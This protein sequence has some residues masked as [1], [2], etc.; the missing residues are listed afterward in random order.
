MEPAS[1]SADVWIAAGTWATVLVLAGTLVYAIKQVGEAQELRRQQ[2]RPWVTVSFH[3][4]SNIAFIAVKN[5]GSTAAHDVRIRFEPELVSA[6]RKQNELA[7]VAMFNEPIPTLVPGE[8]RLAHFERTSDRLSDESL[9]L[10]HRAFVEYTD[11]RGEP[12]EPDQFVLDFGSLM[13]GNL[14][15]KGMHD[16][17]EAVIKIEKKLSGRPQRP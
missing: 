11:H 3:F 7:E 1:V 6:L 15:D 2:F 14:P 17:A 4:R 16:L 13:G 12:L 9:P 5:L 10:R 8:E